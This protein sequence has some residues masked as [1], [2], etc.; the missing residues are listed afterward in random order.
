MNRHHTCCAILLL[1]LLTTGCIG[2]THFHYQPGNNPVIETS[3][4]S[5]SLFEYT[6]QPVPFENRILYEEESKN[7]VLRHIRIPSIGNN[8]QPDNLISAR[9][10]QSKQPG[11]KGLIIVLPIWGSSIYPPK[12]ITNSTLKKSKGRLNVLWVEGPQQLFDWEELKQSTNEDA[13]AAAVNNTTDRLQTNVIDIRRL[14]DWSEA[15]P[16]IDPQRIGLVGFS[17]S[18]IATG[19]VLSHDRR[20]DASVLVM[21]A[22][23]PGKMIARC[24]GRLADVREVI[25][26][27]FNW[28]VD[29][30]QKFVEGIYHDL[31]PAIYIS[32]ANP[33]NV[34]IIDAR[35]D[36]CMPESARDAL[37]NALGQPE[38]ITIN[39]GHKTSFLAMTP[40]GFNFLSGAIVKFLRRHLDTGT[41]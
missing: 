30:Y 29:K 33:E 39:Y 19:L 17:I 5:S 35:N 22:A 9:Y 25:T 41:Q 2:R 27:R 23:Q 26:E 21:G 16:E 12:K 15:Q 36:A 32:K 31:D 4:P 18:A 37:W 14:I 10:Y 38:R 11:V 7:Y 1:C 8:A 3:T 6:Q 40:V 34:L 28:T 13:F 20:V 24:Y